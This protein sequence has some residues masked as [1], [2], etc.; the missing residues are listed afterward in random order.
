MWK[1]VW[2][3]GPW[4]ARGGRWEQHT[5]F[6]PLVVSAQLSLGVRQEEN[7]FGLWPCGIGLS[8]GFNRLKRL[9]QAV[10]FHYT[11]NEIF[12]C[13]CYMFLVFLTWL[14]LTLNPLKP[15]LFKLKKCVLKHDIWGVPIHVQEGN[16]ALAWKS[17]FPSCYTVVA[18]NEHYIRKESQ[19]GDKTFCTFTLF[20]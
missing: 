2:N 3:M 9:Q 10:F 19:K 12:P 20:E 11:V 15:M 17:T 1:F 7:M 16:R 18:S 8:L 4:K 14:K 13:M 6:P 5:S